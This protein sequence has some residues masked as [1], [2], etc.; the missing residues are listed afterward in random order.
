MEIFKLGV[1]DLGQRVKG[2]TLTT[3]TTKAFTFTHGTTLRLEMASHIRVV[4]IEL[5]VPNY[6]F[7]GQ[8]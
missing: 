7:S 3:T 8:S 4:R 2:F 1:K 6:L 5:L